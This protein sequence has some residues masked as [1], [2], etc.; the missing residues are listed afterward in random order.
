MNLEELLQEASD[1][2]TVIRE[3]VEEIKGRLLQAQLDTMAARAECKRIRERLLQLRKKKVAVVWLGMNDIR[4]YLGVFETVDAA[5]QFL[6]D[7]GAL[8]TTWGEIYSKAVNPNKE[9]LM[10]TDEFCA[11][12]RDNCKGL[13]HIYSVGPRADEMDLHI[14]EVPMNTIVR[15]YDD[16]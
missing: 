15:G 11:W 14:T 5:K 10:V 9:V 16:D 6:V 13:P 12:I 4:S 3:Y 8:K 7:K 2:M 1:R